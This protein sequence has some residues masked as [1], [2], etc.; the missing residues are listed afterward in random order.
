MPSTNICLVRLEETESEARYWTGLRRLGSG[1]VGVAEWAGPLVDAGLELAEFPAELVADAVVVPAERFEVAGAGLMGLRPGGFVVE[2]A[3]VGGHPASGEDTVRIA[4]FH[5]PFLGCAGPSSGGDHCHRLSILIEGG[6]LPLR[7]GLR[8]RDLA[9]YIG[10]DRS[11]TGDLPGV[12]IQTEQCGQPDSE[13]DHSTVMTTAMV[14]SAEQ[15]QEHVGSH[16]VDAAGIVLAL[17][18]LGQT[19]DPAQAAFT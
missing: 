3:L 18:S 2:V 9:G 5:C 1:Q 11:P 4:G 6:D 17:G 13:I 15:V 10:A 12:L 7:A 16:L 8:F 14:S 19:V